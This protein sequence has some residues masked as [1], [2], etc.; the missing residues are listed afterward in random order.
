MTK[1]NLTEEN[2]EKL[3]K[4]LKTV[5]SLK[6]KKA[7]ETIQK[8]K[9]PTKDEIRLLKQLGDGPENQPAEKQ[10]PPSSFKSLRQVLPWLAEQSPQANSPLGVEK[11]TLA[12]QG[13]PIRLWL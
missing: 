10:K 2:K 5:K 7:I 11:S 6:L 9:I 3:S 13:L 12:I 8:G 1:N 4:I